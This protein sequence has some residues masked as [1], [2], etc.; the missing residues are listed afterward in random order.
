M[1]ILALTNL[2]PPHYVG[3]YELI[4]A[5]VLPELVHRG[6]HVQILTSNHQTPGIPFEAVSP[7]IERTLRLHGFY[8]HPWHGIA[9]LLGL[10]QHNNDTLR[11]AL[12]RFRPDL[13][14]VWNM[15]GLSKSMLFTLQDLGFP[16]V[17]YLSDHWIARG[18]VADVW[19]RWWNQADPG[20]KKKTARTLL[21][22][23]GFKRQ[24]DTV[25]PARPISELRFPRIYFCS[26][27]LRDLTTEAG[28]KVAHGAVI[29]CPVNINKFDGQPHSAARPLRKLLYAGRLAADKG[30]MTALRAMLLTRG[31]FNGT[32]TICGRGDASYVAQLKE[33]AA[34]H[35]LP[36]EFI[37]ASQNELP[38]IYRSHDALLFTSEWEEPFALTPLEAMACGLPVI[39]TMTGGSKELFRNEENA[40][41][42]TAGSPEQLADRIL[43]L[44]S[45]D[46]LRARIAAEG[47]KEVRGNYSESRIVDQIEAYLEETLQGWTRPPGSSALPHAQQE[48][49]VA[50]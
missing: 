42:Y 31:R 44:A 2:Y 6:H 20:L 18:I 45:D 10:E 19:L 5:A 21:T 7:G 46:Q 29:Y 25:A 33:F 43:Q 22:R 41:T 8:G 9:T 32:L 26:K 35:T 16:T 24:W 47:W 50:P 1:R 30:V 39:G 36:V 37:A 28:W 38:S 49:L 14:Y 3:G 40:L 15:G 12:E 27:A 4:C 48:A 13:V 23:L 17:F 11:S 34:R